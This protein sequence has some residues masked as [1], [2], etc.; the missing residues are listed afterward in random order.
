MKQNFFAADWEK[1]L[2]VPV[3]AAHPEYEELY[4]KA[5]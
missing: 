1:Y 2:P 5:W 4:K 3:Y